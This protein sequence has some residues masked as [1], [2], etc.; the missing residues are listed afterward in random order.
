MNSIESVTL[1][2]NTQI[3]ELGKINNDKIS[4]DLIFVGSGDSYIAGLIV[5]YVTDHKCVCYSPSDLLYSKFDC[6]KTYCFISVSGR[7][8][9][10]ITVA[11]R[12][13]EAG[14][15]T[16]A[17][18]MNKDS[19]LS[20][21]CKRTVPI[22]CKSEM[23]PATS[24]SNFTTSVLTCLQIAGVKIPEKFDIWHD[25]GVKLSQKI[26]DSGS[27]PDN[28]NKKTFFILGND[29]LYSLAL[30]TSL[31]MTEFFGTTAIAHKL[32][33]FCHSP[34][35]GIKNS[36]QLCVL[37]KKEEMISQKLNQLGLNISYVEL[38]NEDLL[39]QLFESI[40]FVQKLM[41]LLAEKIGFTELKYLMM[42]PVLEASSDLIYFDNISHTG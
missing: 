14:V 15:N 20:Q 40:F 5:E 7:T 6:D 24:F 41:L 18:T 33:E 10:N 38:F 21:A 13:T 9:S 31:K 16:I 23:T 39:S 28:I 11:R 42:K 35:F 27:F 19:M 26:F 30:Y 17:V 12:A 29:I 4:D 34:I 22:G 2:F 37:G 32:E 36:H 1:D 25:N 8:K 3:S